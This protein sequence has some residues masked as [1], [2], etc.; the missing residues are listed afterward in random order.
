MAC[1]ET[2]CTLRT[3]CTQVHELPQGFCGDNGEGTLF[4]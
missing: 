2:Q 4:S 1:E 3:S